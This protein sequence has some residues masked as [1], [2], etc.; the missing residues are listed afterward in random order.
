MTL[1]LETMKPPPAPVTRVDIPAHGRACLLRRRSP[2]VHVPKSLVDRISLLVAY[3]GSGHV[4]FTSEVRN[5]IRFLRR[6]LRWV[7][8]QRAQE[9]RDDIEWRK[10]IE[11]VENDRAQVEAEMLETMARQI[12]RVRGETMDDYLARLRAYRALLPTVGER[13]GIITLLERERNRN[14]GE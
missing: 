13:S 10:A 7:S 1:Y 4:V 9:A 12:P 5:E 14:G 3:V 2:R 8:A 6:E 11:W